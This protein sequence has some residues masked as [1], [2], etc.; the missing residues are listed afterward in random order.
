MEHVRETFPIGLKDKKRGGPSVAWIKIPNSFAEL[1]TVFE[2][3]KYN[4]P[5]WYKVPGVMDFPEFAGYYWQ[6][7]RRGHTSSDL[8][9]MMDADQK[10]FH[11]ILESACRVG[12]PPVCAP[13]YFYYTTKLKKA[14]LKAMFQRRSMIPDIQWNLEPSSCKE[15]NHEDWPVLIEYVQNNVWMGEF[16]LEPPKVWDELWF[17]RLVNETKSREDIPVRKEIV[18]LVTDAGLPLT[19][20]GRRG[21]RLRRKWTEGE[22]STIREAAEFIW[23]NWRARMEGE[24]EF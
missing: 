11:N 23:S 8:R 14:E 2:N 15:E 20:P 5:V 4:P 9:N 24:L 18:K 7:N 22:T 6:H 19:W 21:F 13:D 17:A 1:M 16:L 12:K 3:P 10:L